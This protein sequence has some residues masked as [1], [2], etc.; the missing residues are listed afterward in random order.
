MILCSPLG[1]SS[2][3]NNC[4]WF[5]F[6]S[7]WNIILPWQLNYSVERLNFPEC[8]EL[9]WPVLTCLSLGITWQALAVC[10][11]YGFLRWIWCM[12]LCY[13]SSHEETGAS[14]T[15]YGHGVCKWPGCESICEDFGQF[16]KY[17]LNHF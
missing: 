7:N 14:H 15:L 9:N 13:S 4:L 10:N 1:F 2:F 17:V 11:D 16:L 3:I 5:Y 8:S 6:P 12:F